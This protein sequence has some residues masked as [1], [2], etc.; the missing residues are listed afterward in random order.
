MQPAEVL[1]WLVHCR[2]HS[3]WSEY[4]RLVEDSKTNELVL[5]FQ[6][7]KEHG[8][9]API[10]EDV[11]M[12]QCYIY[13]YMVST[14]T[15]NWTSLTTLILWNTAISDRRKWRMENILKRL[16][17]N[18]LNNHPHSSMAWYPGAPSAS[19]LFHQGAVPQCLL[20]AC[21]PALRT[22]NRTESIL[23]SY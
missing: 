21:S 1:C 22:D 8:K 9:S 20:P 10:Q 18:I 13:K 23:N 16:L 5:D 19:S 4:R 6:C 3:Q 11:E 7:V 14:W 15:T 12:V 17:D 2:V